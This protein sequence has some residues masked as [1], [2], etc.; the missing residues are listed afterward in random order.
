[1]IR[2]VAHVLGDSPHTEKVCAASRRESALYT[3]AIYKLELHRC[4]RVD[5]LGE[6]PKRNSILKIEHK[7]PTPPISTEMILARKRVCGI[8][9]QAVSLNLPT[10]SFLPNR[11]HASGTLKD[12]PETSPPQLRSP[13]TEVAQVGFDKASSLESCPAKSDKII[14][15]ISI[16]RRRGELPNTASPTYTRPTKHESTALQLMVADW[17]MILLSTSSRGF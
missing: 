9:T 1:M 6:L 7:P 2:I 15:E 17:S 8:R 16:V 3:H 5:W 12:L 13:A 4:L 10:A 14:Y 11:K